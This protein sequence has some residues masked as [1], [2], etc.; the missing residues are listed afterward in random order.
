MKMDPLLNKAARLAKN[1]EY[2]NALNVLK[3][4]EDRYNG[5][6][7]YYSLL[8]IICLYAGNFVEALD[9]FKIA[10]QRKIQDPSILL[11][12]AVLHLKRM[13]TS[14]AVDNYLDVQELDPKNKIAKHALDVIR[15]HSSPESLADWMTPEKLAKLYP[16]IPSPAIE[17][18]TVLLFISFVIVFFALTFALLVRLHVIRDPFKTRDERVTSEFVLSRYERAQPVEIDGSFKYI[19]TR[20][21]ALTLYDRAMGLFSDYRD[22]AAKVNLNRILESNASEGLKNKAHL[23][24][25]FMETPGFTTFNRNDNPSFNDVKN[26]PVL[27]RDVHV[28]WRGVATNVEITEEYTSFDFLVGYDTRTTLEGIVPVVFFM[29][30][31]INTERPLEVLGKIQV[32]PSNTDI[33]LEGVAVHQSARLEE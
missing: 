9:N 5:S 4:E 11:G 19:L 27:Y 28:I 7:K 24:I 12:F 26:E 6:H 22:E 3:A 30:V 16:P 15:K 1:K 23:M 2:D 25:S 21:Q 29:P 10:R 31:S 14:Q 17:A 8:G 32:L 20:D 18:K 33:T 13:N